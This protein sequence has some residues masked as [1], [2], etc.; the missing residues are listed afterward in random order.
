MT[1]PNGVDPKTLRC[2]IDGCPEFSERFTKDGRALCHE[3]WAT[4]WHDHNQQRH[5]TWNRIM[6][7]RRRAAYAASR[8]QP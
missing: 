2:A 3:H 7:Q 1:I 6:H 4:E 8:K 5:R